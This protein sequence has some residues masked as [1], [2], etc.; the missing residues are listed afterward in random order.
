MA[1]FWL[2]LRSRASASTARLPSPIGSRGTGIGTPGATIDGTTL[3]TLET[4]AAVASVGA[5]WMITARTLKS[6][7]SVG[8]T[9]RKRSLSARHMAL[10]TAFLIRLR[11]SSENGTRA[12]AAVSAVGSIRRVFAARTS[13]LL[14]RTCDLVRSP[15]DGVR[16]S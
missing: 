2:P 5:T 16:L 6:A 11:C 9:T 1:A 13:A 7:V 15:S 14:T 12:A 10:L 4:P 8:A 3:A